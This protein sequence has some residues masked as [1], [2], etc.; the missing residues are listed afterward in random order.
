MNAIERFQN[1]LN[2]LFQFEASDLDFGV[3]RILNYKRSLI[4]NF[5]NK[6]LVEKVEAEFAKHKDEKLINIDQKLK[7]IKERILQNFGDGAFTPTNELKD[8][9]KNTPLGKEYLSIKERGI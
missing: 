7:D 5:I 3:Y 4:S 9:F 2:E 1:L 6:D 8:E